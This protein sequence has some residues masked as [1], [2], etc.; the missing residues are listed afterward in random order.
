MNL[1]EI[2]TTHLNLLNNIIEAGGELTPEMEQALQMSE[3]SIQEKG[4]NYAKFI[5]TL[6]AEAETIRVREKELADIRKLREN[7][8][9]RLRLN[10]SDAMEQL[11]LDKIKDTTHSITFRKSK[12]VMIFDEN[13]IP[14]QY[15]SWI[16]TI[17]KTDIKKAIEMGINVPGATLTTN[18]S[19]QIK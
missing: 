4:I 6:E 2:T 16:P 7:L 19:I 17:S 18:Q 14:S 10:L 15:K 9:N 13:E 8:A 1:Y 12:S 5:R 3:M 11:N